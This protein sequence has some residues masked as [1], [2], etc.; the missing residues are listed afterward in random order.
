MRYYNFFTTGEDLFK[1][2]Q[3]D[4]SLKYF[5][6]FIKFNENMPEGYEN[7]ALCYSMMGNMQQ[8][9][10]VYEEMINNNIGDLKQL[11]SRIQNS[12]GHYLSNSFDES[13]INLVN[14]LNNDNLAILIEICKIKN[15]IFCL[16]L[17][18]TVY[19]NEPLNL[20]KHYLHI[21]FLVETL[22]NSMN[23]ELFTYKDMFIKNNQFYY[24][25]LCDYFQGHFEEALEMFLMQK[26]AI[27]FSTYS[28]D[29]Q[30]INNFFYLSSFLRCSDGSNDDYE[31]IIDIYNEELKNGNTSLDN[32]WFFTVYNVYTKFTKYNSKDSVDYILDINN[33][34]NKRINM[35]MISNIEENDKI[36]IKV[37]DNLNQIV[38]LKDCNIFTHNNGIIIHDG[39]NLYVGKNTFHPYTTEYI[40]LNKEVRN[41]NG[42]VFSLNIC[43][44]TNYFHIIVEII[45]KI[46]ILEKYED[47]S[48]IKLVISNNLPSYGKSI[49]NY[50]N[51]KEIIYYTDGVFNCQELIYVD[52][53]IE[54][55]DYK[56]CWSC[57]LPTKLALDSLY[58][59]FIKPKET[60]KEHVVYISRSESNIRNVKNEDLL[61]NKVLKP[62]YGDDLVIFDNNFLQNCNNKFKS[63]IELFNNAKLVIGAHGAGLTNLIFCRENTPVLEFLLKPNCNRCFEY[64]AKYRGL[65]YIPVDFITAFYHTSY[66]FE[67]KHIEPLLNLLKSINKKI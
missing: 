31:M 67:E 54:S 38:Y 50:F 34:T 66:N 5:N 55:D 16:Q 49:L 10:S 33:Q 3:Y 19:K 53:G 48:N 1:K 61:L 29:I 12:I 18:I 59:R 45:S 28:K 58:N 36:K 8:C 17:I 64:L 32:W 6:K 23:Y 22:C 63:Q 43:N 30:N 35:N 46:C 24:I 62:L 42:K 65:N 60:Y 56:D 40:T 57:Y 7:K 9:I 41:L 47:L 39:K 13:Q 11:E 26:N 25:G 15:P 44:Q 21:R 2:G 52:I 27:D 20:E 51:F 14:K 37:I 4:K